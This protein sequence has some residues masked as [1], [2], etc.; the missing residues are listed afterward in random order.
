MLEQAT[1]Q[2]VSLLLLRVLLSEQQLH[3]AFGGLVADEE[4]R[5]RCKDAHIMSID[6]AD[7]SQHEARHTISTLALLGQ[8]VVRH[9]PETSRDWSAPDRASM[10]AMADPG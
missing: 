4:W 8:A 6:S 5:R 1:Q 7:A 9:S 2:R 3:G 10:A